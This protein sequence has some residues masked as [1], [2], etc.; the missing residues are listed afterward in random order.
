MGV[1]LVDGVERSRHAAVQHFY[2][3]IQARHP[4]L[5]GLE[6]ANRHAKLHPLFKV[7][8]RGV[9]G[10]ADDAQCLGSQADAAQVQRVVQR[11]GAVCAGGQQSTRGQLHAVEHHARVVAAVGHVQWLHLQARGACGH[12]KQADRPGATIEASDD[13]EGIGAHCVNHK[14]FLTLQKPLAGLPSG[15]GGDAVGVVASAFVQCQGQAQTAFDQWRKPTVFLGRIT[16]AAQNTAAQ[17][18]RGQQGQRRE[19]ATAGLQDAPHAHIAHAQT[20][21]VF[22]KNGGGPA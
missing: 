3:G 1:A 22:G 7:G 6:G 4:V 12:H 10:V 16:G 20:A 11:L 19:V 21:I 17:H 2:L 8:Q 5:Q 13:D 9:K 15:A 14:P 18:R